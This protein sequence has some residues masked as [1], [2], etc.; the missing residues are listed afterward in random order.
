[1]NWL[2]FVYDSV[3]VMA[4]LLMSELFIS[5]GSFAALISIVC[6]IVRLRD[7]FI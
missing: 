5:L 6:V 3:N 7:A 4:P 2:S 1:M